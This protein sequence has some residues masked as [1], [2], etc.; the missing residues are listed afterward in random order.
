MRRSSLVSLCF[1]ILMSSSA[2]FGKFNA[3][4]PAGPKQAVAFAAQGNA[5]M[6]IVVPASPSAAE[7]LAAEELK[8]HLDRITGGSFQIVRDD[9]EVTSR[10]IGIGMTAQ[11]RQA[12]L[13]DVNGIFARAFAKADADEN[14]RLRNR[15]ETHYAPIAIMEIDALFNAYPGNMRGF[16]AQRYKQLLEH[17]RR[18]TS[19]QNMRAYS[20]LRTMEGRLNE[21]EVLLNFIEGGLGV[22]RIHSVN[23]TLYGYPKRSDPLGTNG[24]AARLPC[25][26]AWLVQWHFPGNLI[27][28]GVRYQLRAQLRAETEAGAGHVANAG[29]H[30]PSNLPAS[31]VFKIDGRT[32]S[33]SEYRWIDLGEPFIPHKDSF[34]WF[35]ANAGSGI[36]G[37]FVNE[38]ELTP[39]ASHPF[40]ATSTTQ[41]AP[42][43]NAGT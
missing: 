21:L 20:E 14:V 42:H 18:I 1:V 33:S 36:G 13:E 24:M 32:L 16:P 8:E 28:P 31:W 2:S 23:G 39:H 35:S 26:N 22:L 25:D 19:S 43:G 6:D 41:E 10:F 17:V 15:I 7:I 11:A 5:L 30:C 40:S 38:I 34:I 37:L 27:R 9:A 12:G 4:S 29:V 3:L